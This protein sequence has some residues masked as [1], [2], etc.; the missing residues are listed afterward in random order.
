MQYKQDV[1]W[2]YCHSKQAEG[3]VTEVNTGS[4]LDFLVFIWPCSLSWLHDEF[5][6]KGCAMMAFER[7]KQLLLRKPL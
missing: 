6:L 5:W 4:W 2:D 1:F 7:F 3:I